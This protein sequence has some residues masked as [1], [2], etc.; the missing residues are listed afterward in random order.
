V[1]YRQIFS[2]QIKRISGCWH[3][4]WNKSVSARKHRKKTRLRHLRWFWASIDIF[5]INVNNPIFYIY[6][7]CSAKYL[8]EC[9]TDS[10]R[11]KN[12]AL[13]VSWDFPVRLY[14][15]TNRLHETWRNNGEIIVWRHITHHVLH[16]RHLD[17]FLLNAEVYK[18]VW[19]EEYV[20][21]SHLVVAQ[22]CAR[23]A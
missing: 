5:H 8:A 6:R 19:S 23:V 4:I 22:R 14:L 15:G 17:Y 3:L 13:P 1:E 18:S 7:K 20:N 10:V 12:L 16:V 21:E 2:Y 11:W 9:E